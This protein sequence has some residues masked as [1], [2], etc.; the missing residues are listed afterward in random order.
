MREDKASNGAFPL[1]VCFIKCQT[2][3]TLI[4]GLCMSKKLRN[5]AE[6]GHLRGVCFRL[7]GVIYE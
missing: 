7:M 2:P 5:K 3:Q 4:M 1:D 6:N